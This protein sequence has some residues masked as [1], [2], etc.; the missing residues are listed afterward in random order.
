M[1]HTVTYHYLFKTAEEREADKDLEK[2]EATKKE[3]RREKKEQ[4]AFEEEIESWKQYKHFQPG[5]NFHQAE[6]ISKR[7]FSILMFS[8]AGGGV[9][10]RTSYHRSCDSFPQIFFSRC[11]VH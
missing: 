9:G 4:K 5:K 8:R 2:T 10:E 6:I 1:V 3:E 7:K 11:E